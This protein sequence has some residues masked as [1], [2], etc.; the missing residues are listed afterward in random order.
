MILK[1]DINQQREVIK[2][3]FADIRG[4]LHDARRLCLQDEN[5][6][7]TLALNVI[8]D[9]LNKLET[10]I[11]IMDASVDDLKMVAARLR[12]QRDQAYRHRDEALRLYA[13]E[14]YDPNAPPAPRRSG[15]PKPPVA[16]P[17]RLF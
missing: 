7:L 9:W 4:A 3:L 14:K 5:P 6:A 17:Q 10:E 12:Q 13:A 16:V 11:S 1:D 15:K 2:A 8:E